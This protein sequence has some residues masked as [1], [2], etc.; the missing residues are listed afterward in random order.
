MMKHVFDT[1]ETGT[2]TA[3]AARLHAL[4]DDIANGAVRL[5][6]DEWEE[7]TAVVDPVD[8]VID[9]RRGRH[10]AELMLRMRWSTREDHRPPAAGA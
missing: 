4:A 9:V 6:Y 7:P 8:V 1:S 10:H 2:H 3:I 5:S